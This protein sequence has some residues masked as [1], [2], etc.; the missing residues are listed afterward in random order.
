MML[1]A[2]S[3]SASLSSSAVGDASSQWHGVSL[4]GWLVMEINPSK[5]GPT[6]PMDLRPQWMFDQIEANSELDLVSSLR[7]EHGDDY[8]IATMRNHWAGYITDDMLDAAER[9]GIDTFR[10]PVGYWIADKPVGG[11]SPLEYGIS[12]E[13]FVTGGLNHLYAMLV[14]MKRRGMRALIDIHA[15]P[16]NSACVSNG[17]YCAAPL[18]FGVLREWPVPEGEEGI[19]DAVS[20][21][22]M[23]RC[24]HADPAGG[25]VYPTTRARTDGEG[26][27][28]D[29]AVNTVGE[30]SK[31]IKALPNEASCVVAYQLA[32]EPAL[33]PDIPAVTLGI[34]LFYERAIATAREQLPSIP[35]VLSWINPS[36]EVFPFLKKM[37]DADKT[38]KGGGVISDH[39]YYLNWQGWM[40]PPGELMPWA[41]MHRRACVLEAEHEQRVLELYSNVKQDV[42]IG[43]WSLATNMDA[44]LDLN[45][46]DVIGSLKTLYRAQL[47]AFSKVDVIRGAFF[48]TLRMGSGWDPR[49][50]DAFPNGRQLDGTSASRSLDGYPFQV[51]SLLEMERMGVATALNQPYKGTCAA[52]L[53]AAAA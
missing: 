37:G 1:A 40:L 16:C 8:A 44:P 36:P 45:D 2:A 26:T 17:L 38:A 20:I 51:W 33:G 21:A 29:V 22:D 25:A 14:K 48:W 19:I 3:P 13:G 18:A 34:N 53:A 28:S 24:A 49:P 9:L 10:I 4:G 31:W 23:P 50:T 43:E 52:V 15:H 27:W 30:L 12:P 41:E 35:L 39:H 5:R 46:P 11:K 47:E 42:I 7:R 6:S 32:N